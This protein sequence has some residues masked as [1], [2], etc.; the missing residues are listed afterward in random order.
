MKAAEVLVKCLENEG[1]EY[2]FGIPGEENL[3]VMDALLDS[4]IKFITTRHEQGAAFMA[5]VYGR[6]TGR[7][8]VCLSTLGPGATNLVTGVADANMDHAPL[9]AIAGQAGTNRLHKESHQ[10]LDL[11]DIFRPITKYT[12]RI[13]TPNIIP[14][15]VRKAFKVAQTE[16]TGATFIE[17][18]ENLAKMEI[19]E[20]P[21]QV[22]H[23]HQPEPPQD[24]VEYAAELISE[25]RHP[26]ILAGNGV[27]RARAWKHLED[28]ATKLNIP[29]ANTFMAKGVMPFRHPMTL[30]SAGLQS[31]DY[32]SCGFDRADLVICIGYDLV[33]YHPYLWHP[34]RDRKIIHI[35]A[36]HAEVDQAYT[37]AAGVVGDIKHSL[38]RI[39]ELATPYEGNLMRPLREA[40]IKEMN[41]LSD[42][43]EF[44]VKPQKIIW[45]LRTAMDLEDIVICDVGAHKMWMARMF[46]CE[47]PN[48][49]II[50]NGF[51][52]MGIAVPGAI[53]AKM[54]YP[55]RS[56]VAV[57]GDA[58]FMMNSQEIETA[59][60]YKVPIVI[61]IW[62][63]ASYGLIEWKQMNEFGRKSNV[64]F[65]NPDFV[66][67]AESF[68]ARGYR[69]NNTDDLLPTLREAL[70]S[71]ELCIIDCPVDYRENVKLTEK[72]G[73]MV[74]PV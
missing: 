59:M 18:P 67:Y 46:R 2:I 72:L 22:K 51:A 1:V 27:I 54:L 36:S 66:K 62:N 42:D 21:L 15:V 5:D 48:T 26:L 14:E 38:I 60:R 43:R 33:E 74:C 50:S 11:E 30:G 24:R 34:T 20:L 61:L 8:G 13:L 65:T 3:D 12:S 17:F 52:S 6:L 53:A 57:T 73:E 10:V 55:E 40:L 28:F 44:P 58:G 68:G 19:D 23:P 45:D 7:A 35:D 63:D 47:H 31:M 29:V 9:V 71:G 69:I 70:D 37:V 56:V 16:K 39:G 4:K 64:E 49:C 32:V 25:A 41:H